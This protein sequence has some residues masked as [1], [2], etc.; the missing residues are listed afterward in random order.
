MQGDY[1]EDADTEAAD[2]DTFDYEE[3]YEETSDMAYQ[4][5]LKAIEDAGIEA[6]E[7]DMIIVATST[8]DF[9]FP[10]VANILQEKLGV[11]KVASMDQ[12][13]ACS[14]F[15]YAMINAKQFVQSGDYK[16]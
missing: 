2:E 14:G 13:A 1:E 12:L 8:G 7:I 5:S 11:G 9:P 15:M 6:S 4:A 16:K 10:T 3:A